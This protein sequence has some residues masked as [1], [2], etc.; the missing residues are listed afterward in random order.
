[1]KSLNIAGKYAFET[2]P[3]ALARAVSYRVIPD[4]KRKFVILDREG[5]RY[6]DF[7]SGEEIP[8]EGININDTQLV[9]N[10]TPGTEFCIYKD[11]VL[12]GFILRAMGTTPAVLRDGGYIEI[13]SEVMDEMYNLMLELWEIPAE[14]K[15]G[16]EAFVRERLHFHEDDPGEE[17]AHIGMFLS[18]PGL[19][20]T[21]YQLE[22][23]MERAYDSHFITLVK[24]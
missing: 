8:A 9:F 11:P 4:S 23:Y 1:M 12:S 21:L 7:N 19:R 22:T 24:L 10:C 2:V 20:E 14:D 17:L 5:G 3:Q 13:P 16:R 6:V 18:D 15:K